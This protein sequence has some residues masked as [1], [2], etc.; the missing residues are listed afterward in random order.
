MKPGEIQIMEIKEISQLAAKIKGNIGKVLFG[1]DAELDL[2]LVALLGSGHALLDDV[3]G[4]GKTVLAKSLAKSVSCDFSRIQFT[5]DLL[6]S[7]IT[8]LNV[9]NQKEGEFQFQPGPAFTNILLADEIN[10]TTPRTQSALLECME[11]RQITVDGVTKVLDNP[12]FVIATQNPVETAGTFSLPEAQL[13]RFLLRLK[14]GYPTRE[15]TVGIIQSQLGGTP[16]TTLEA[17]CTGADI[18][19]AQQAV[20]SIKISDAV[21]DYIVRLAEAT[22]T[23]EDLSLGVSTRGILS[24]VRACQA[25]A[26]IDGRDYVL[27]DDVKL[28]AEPVFAHRIL[29]KSR[30]S[31]SDKAPEIIQRL[32]ETVP[33]P[34]ED[35][36]ARLEEPE[37]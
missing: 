5:A 15:E 17:V 11:E 2:V 14:L 33:A 16:L 23:H 31:S 10:R 20:K 9:Y 21:A 27:P 34:T 19:A 36:K 35:P 25:L 28:L 29:L 8:G 32:L 37:K 1:K 22:R 13:D 18:D 6:P 12:F 4:T 26:A 3:P 7:D 30:Y 24:M